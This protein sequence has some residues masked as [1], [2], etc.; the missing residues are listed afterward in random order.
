MK[1]L[2][3]L[4]VATGL[5]LAGEAPG[6]DKA[7]SDEARLQGTWSLI[8]VEIDGQLLDMPQFR[9]ARLVIEGT[10]YSF[11]LGDERMEMRHAVHPAMDPKGLDMTITEGPLTGKTF[12]A[13]YELADGRLRIC[14][15]VEPDR[16]RPTAFIATPGSELMMIVWR[17]DRP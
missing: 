15:S 8:S 4:L 16:P 10:R 2:L 9:Q 5:L 14:R 13:I 6:G 12:H 3:I 7:P 11:R 17:R 1:R